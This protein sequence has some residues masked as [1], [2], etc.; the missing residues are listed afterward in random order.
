MGN[1][2]RRLEELIQRWQGKADRAY[3]RYQQGGIQRDMK[4]YEDADELVGYLRRALNAAAE[5]AELGAIRVQ[6]SD[7]CAQAIRIAG[8]DDKAATESLIRNMKAYGVSCLHLF[9]PY[10][11]R[12]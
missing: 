6:L 8:S 4:A 11:D 7:F 5:H 9:D 3:D 1:D 2:N 10:A 12:R